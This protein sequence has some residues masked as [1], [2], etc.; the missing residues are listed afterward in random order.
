MEILLTLKTFEINM[1]FK[2]V[3]TAKLNKIIIA[4]NVPGINK[5]II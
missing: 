2:W 4:V 5:G 3:G 1:S